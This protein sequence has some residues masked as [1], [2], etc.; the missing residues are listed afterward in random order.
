MLNISGHVMSEDTAV[1][2]VENGQIVD[3]NSRLVP[4]YL[5][6]TKDFEGWLASRAIDPH[7]TNSRLLKKALR[8]H[9][10]DDAETALAVNAATITD[11][12]WFKAKDS[13]LTY[14][15]VRFKENLFDMLALRGDPDGFSQKP[16]RTPELTNI[17]SYEKC[18]RLID[19][20]WWMYKSGNQNEYFSELFVSRLAERLGLP[21]AHYE[22]DGQYIR[23]K[24]FLDKTDLIFEPLSSIMDDNDDYSDCFDAINRISSK[25]ARQYLEIVWLDTI[26]YNMDRHTGNLGFLRDV[27]SGDVVSMAP[28]YDNNVA[29]IARGYPK[30]VQRENDGIIRFFNDFLKTN[31]CA[32]RMFCGMRFPTIT[33]G[34]ISDCL[35][36]IRFDVDRDYIKTFILSGQRIVKETRR[37]LAEKVGIEILES[38]DG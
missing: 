8:L 26:C 19:G 16:S 30:D 34:I 36:D 17:G 25:I 28:N 1:A 29:L 3:Y 15:D 13:Q 31:K 27:K 22:M 9:P 11:R 4:L 14:E 33:E 18:W 21:T 2:T 32:L 37:G 6:R 38:A 20:S 24:N 23:T 35:D 5:G 10:V 12:Y 7:R